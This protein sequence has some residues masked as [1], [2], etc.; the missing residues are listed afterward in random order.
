[1][2]NNEGSL[3]ASLWSFN[4]NPANKDRPFYSWFTRKEFRQAMSC[5]LNRER[6][7]N[8]VY[9]GLAFPKYDFF[10]EPNPYYNADISLKYRYS[11]QQAESLLSSAG[12]KKAPD[13]T[14]RDEQGRA[15]EFDLSLSADNAIGSDIASIIVDDCKVAGIKVTIRQVDF[16]TLVGQLTGSYDWQSVLI[17][18]GTMLF[19]TQGSNVW[20]TTGNLHL[21]YPLQKTPETDWEAR[22]DYLYNEGSVTL[23]RDKARA[24]WNEYQEIILEQCPVVYL[25]RARTFVGLYNKWDFS[26]VYYDNMGGFQVEKAWLK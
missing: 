25:V 19:P 6:I 8:Q 13:G 12:F 7:I 10:P 11:L 24:I 17:G 1:V 3:G 18:L 4:Q 22:V 20:P 21:W 23:D 16:Q 15:V 26:N 5:L 2:F 9:R 14:L